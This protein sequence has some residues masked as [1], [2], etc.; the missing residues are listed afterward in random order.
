MHSFSYIPSI[1]AAILALVPYYVKRAVF[2]E[3]SVAPLTVNFLLTMIF[4][5]VNMTFVY[6]I[7][8]KVGMIYTD[9]EV[10]REGND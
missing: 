6:M 9:A 7:L 2:H 10:L 5:S 1:I 8:S 4:L 3:E